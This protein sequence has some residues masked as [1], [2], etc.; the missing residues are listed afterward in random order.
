MFSALET[1]L[2]VLGGILTAL[3]LG[4]FLMKHIGYRQCV[5][6]ERVVAARQEGIVMAAK[7]A[8][9]Q[10]EIE[11]LKAYEKAVNT[12]VT[13]APIVRVCKPSRSGTVLQTG[14][15]QGGTNAA[16]DVRS[17]VEGTNVIVEWDS[18]PVIQLGREADAQ[19]TY[20]QGYIRDNL[21][22]YARE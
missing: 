7:L 18:A 22:A 13:D 12:P 4:A 17:E 3:L 10:S 21:R 15:A 5:E 20:L 8:A 16:P 11:R 1:K 14:A 6:K 2:L 9:A 19:V